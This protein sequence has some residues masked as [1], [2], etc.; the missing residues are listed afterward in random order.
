[1]KK[2]LLSLSLLTI[3][4]ANGQTTLFEDS[5]DTYGDFII[6]NIGNWT[7]VDGDLRPTYGFTGV[8]FANTNVAKSFQVFNS[9]ATTPALTSSTTSDW[10]ARTGLKNLV[11]I[12]AV[13]NATVAANDDWLISPQITLGTSGNMLSFWAKSCSST[14]GLEKFRVGISTTDTATTSFTVISDDPVQTM[15]DVTYAEYTYN[16]DAYA[17][18]SIYISINC[19]S[20]D[21]FGFAIDD[22]LVTAAVMHT[23]SFFKNNF[24][25]QPNPVSDVF[26][27]TA[28]NSVA[29]ENIKVMDINGRIVSENNNT[30]GS[31][32]MQVNIG[33]LN[34]GV[35]FV[36]VQSELGVGTSKII[37]K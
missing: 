17:G 30:N 29:I 32:A 13:P 14:Y 27:V 12:A 34:A 19:V 22:F 37:K 8:T 25:I 33:E 11:C 16:L 6:S 23:D 18:Q 7:L 10:S 24:S 9:T 28:K 1:M 20:D 21:Q 26:N 15:N 2:L 4:F 3:G 31:D 5:F 36:K 35:Y